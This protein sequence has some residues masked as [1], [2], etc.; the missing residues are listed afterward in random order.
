M[1]SLFNCWFVL[2]ND[3][4]RYYAAAS[5]CV[6]AAPFPWPNRPLAGTIPASGLQSRPYGR[7]FHGT[8]GRG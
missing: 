8:R 7:G 3:T 5:F 4:E 6:V 1:R 2:L